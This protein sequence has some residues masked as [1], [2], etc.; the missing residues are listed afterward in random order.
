MSGSGKRL[1]IKRKVAGICTSDS[2]RCHCLAKSRQ[3]ML[4]M[5]LI[6]AKDGM[7]YYA[8]RCGIDVCGHSERGTRKS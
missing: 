4:Q 8:D 5:H 6:H 7:T 2:I 1:G 3:M